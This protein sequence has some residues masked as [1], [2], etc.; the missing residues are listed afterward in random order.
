MDGIITFWLG[1]RHDPNSVHYSLCND[2]IN[3]ICEFVLKSFTLDDSYWDLYF[4]SKFSIFS[5]RSIGSC[6]KSTLT[7]TLHSLF[8]ES[9]GLTNSKEPCF[10]LSST[11]NIQDSGK[12][13]RRVK[14]IN[15][16]VKANSVKFEMKRLEMKR[17]F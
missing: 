16:K 17:K 4:F 14:K 10:G 5:T 6:G 1:Y 8:P 11:D 3:L 7:H 12:K 15:R 2:I 13:N 9:L